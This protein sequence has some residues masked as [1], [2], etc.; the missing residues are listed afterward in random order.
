M[1]GKLENVLHNGIRK[2]YTSFLYFV[3]ID[4]KF[5]DKPGNLHIN[6]INVMI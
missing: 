5:Y 3:N 2:K 1:S 4:F 6:E